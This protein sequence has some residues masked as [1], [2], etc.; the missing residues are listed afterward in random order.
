MT[1]EPVNLGGQNVLILSS[2]RLG[3]QLNVTLDGLAGTNGLLQLSASNSL[4]VV[5]GNVATSGGLN[6]ECVLYGLLVVPT[7]T[8]HFSPGLIHGEILTG[9][10]QAAL[11]SG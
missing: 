4:A 5:N 11:A 3:N 9:G 8:I 10:N 6:N 2:I 1:I 7:C